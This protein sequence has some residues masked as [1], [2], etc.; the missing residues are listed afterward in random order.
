MILTCAALAG[1]CAW[2]LVPPP[3]EPRLA[4]WRH[5]AAV[6]GDAPPSRRLSTAGW[7]RVAGVS[8]GLAAF[9]LLDGVVG[10]VAAVACVV[11]VPRALTRLE[12]RGERERRD[13]LERQAPLLAD[14]LAAALAS[15]ATLRRSLGVVAPAVGAP[16]SDALQQVIGAIDL[17][18][19]PVDAWR[20]S[21][22]PS[23]HEEIVA[24]VVRSSESGAP[25]ARV[26]EQ[27]AEDLR[28]RRRSAVEVAAR[29][30][31]VRA[32]APLAACFLP[33]FLLLGVVPVVVSLAGSLLDAG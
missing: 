21:P 4:R 11:L 23:A 29:S 3:A 8:A 2:L 20:G 6:K 32:V 17:G 30:A 26:L 1:L 15:G 12:T 25:L 7:A 28:R 9:L 16:T 18:A 14:L 31:G 13:L 5:R 33:A 22:V 27:I 19:D 24:A 10:L